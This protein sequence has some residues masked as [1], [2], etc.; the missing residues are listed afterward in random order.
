MNTEKSI[1]EKLNKWIRNSVTLKL[2]T[3]TILVLLLLIPSSM[4]QSIIGE[5]ERMNTEAAREVSS[6]WANSQEIKGPIL[7]IPLTYEEKNGEEILT[8]TKYVHLLPEHL[9]IHGTIAPEKLRRGIYEVVVYQSSLKVSGVFKL[10]NQFD[11][12]YLKE[13][14]YDEAFI[15][16]GVS[17]LRGIKNHVEFKWRNE[18]LNVTPGSKLQDFSYSGFTVSLPDDF[19]LDNSTIP[20]DFNLNLQGSHHL[21]FQPVGSTTSVNIESTW[22]APSFDGNFLPDFREVREDGFEANW[23]ILQLNRNYPQIWTGNDHFKNMDDSSFGVSLILPMDDYQKSMRSAKYAVM[24]IALTFLIFFLV[25][26]L[27]EKKIHP[28]QYTLVG[29]A[30]CLFYVLLVSISEHSNFNFA[31]WISTTSI[32]TMIMLY[33]LSIFK[34]KRLTILLVTT[35]CGI[36]GFLFI[37]LQLVDYAL[38]MG[39]IGLTIILAATMYFTRNINW[40]KLNIKSE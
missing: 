34:T 3:I 26:I 35:L 25:E 12:S 36:Y 5:R 22:N 15:S 31:Y 9:S 33:S 10:I 6:K 32:V 4:I 24:T 2:I 40:Y 11:R 18:N 39:S 19:R 20:F 37:T 8:Y 23:K 28:F 16:L 7:S 21:S 17:D 13:I 38:L 29:L 27:N 1:F 30:L 14:R